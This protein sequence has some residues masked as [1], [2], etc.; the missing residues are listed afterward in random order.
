VRRVATTDTGTDAKSAVG[1]V[2]AAL[3]VTQLI[4]WGT[5]YYLPAVLGDVMAR[6]LGLSRAEIFSGIAITLIAAALL[7]WPIGRVM[8]RQGAGRSMPAGSGFLAL[9]LVVLGLCQGY[10][11]YA[12]A[13]LLFG[14]G[15]SLA[16]SNAALSAMAQVAGQQARRGIGMVMLF[17]GMAA[18]L[19][20]PLTLWLDGMFG[21]RNV[22]FVFAVLHL[23][24]CAPLHAAVLARATT[25]DRRRD[26][27][28]DDVAGA[29]PAHRRR[30]A[31]LLILVA[32]SCNG[33]VS[34]GLDLHLIGIL[35]KFG[36]SSA[37]AVAVAAW[38]GPATLLARGVDIFSAGRISP[39]ASALAAGVLMP[40][41]LALPIG[42]AGGLMAAVSFI[43]IYSFGTGLMTIARATLP[44]ALL[45][46]QGYAETI[47]R[48]TLPTQIIYA[49]SPMTFGWLL[50]NLGLQ[51]TLWIAF[52]AS[53]VACSA[54]VLLSRLARK[55]ASAARR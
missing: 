13:W 29:M 16:M 14:I 39:M 2:V 28:A 15:M 43:T 46:A 51:P 19:F 44:L 4:S 54:L 3:G 45:G 5:T 52:A 1:R 20:W 41:G 7:A 48:L 40:L 11:T 27:E 38:K 55:S 42:Y 25:A 31:A 53:I 30:L 9:G 35:Q 12:L 34:W 21:W 32:L 47:G 23:A 10:A 22:C 50:E 36:L 26:H 17:G 33:F 8:D 6:D 49:V 18:T 24:V 37:A